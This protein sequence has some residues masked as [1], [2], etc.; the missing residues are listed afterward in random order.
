MLVENIVDCNAINI[1]RLQRNVAH[2]SMRPDF[3]TAKAIAMNLLR[4][5]YDD[6]AVASIKV[7]HCAVCDSGVF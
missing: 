3:L 1:H 6:V 7:M 4:W 5:Q 2:Q